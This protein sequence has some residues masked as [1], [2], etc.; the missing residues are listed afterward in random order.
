MVTTDLVKVLLC[1]QLPAEI[2]LLPRSG[3]TLISRV[4][5]I[6]AHQTGGGVSFTNTSGGAA[7]NIAYWRNNLSVI[8]TEYS[9]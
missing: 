3:S 4:N 2:L 9:N 5:S 8:S 1:Q 7:V 6:K